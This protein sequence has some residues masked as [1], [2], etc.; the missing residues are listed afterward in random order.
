MNNYIKE[1]FATYEEKE[2]EL[3]EEKAASSPEHIFSKEFEKRMER[4]SDTAH[5]VSVTKHVKK[6]KNIRIAAACVVMLLVA[7]SLLPEVRSDAA[8]L[9]Q[10]LLHLQ[11][12]V[13]SEDTSGQQD[14]EFYTKMDMTEREYWNYVQENQLSGKE[15]PAY[16]P[17]GYELEKKDCWYEYIWE[18][19]EDAEFDDSKTLSVTF[20]DTGFCSE[21]KQMLKKKGQI[22]SSDGDAESKNAVLSEIGKVWKNKDSQITFI[23]TVNDWTKRVSY[24]DV[25]GYEKIKL[26]SKEAYVLKGENEEVSIRIYEETSVIHLSGSGMDEDTMYK[27]LVAM[28]ESLFVH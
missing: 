10:K 28:A 9:L 19:K 20:P 13:K 1:H 23:Q 8:D 21:R 16:I 25:K 24:T 18:E 27:E 6:R 11:I 5:K 15:G 14:V 3:L 22:V 17:S 2:I 12:R 4:L 7:G 26:G